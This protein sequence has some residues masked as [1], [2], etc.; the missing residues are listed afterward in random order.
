MPPASPNRNEE[1]GSGF[2]KHDI[3]RLEV[4]VYDASAVRLVQGIGDL[5]CVLEHL[6]KR[7]GSA[8]ESLFES[9]A[10][11]NSMTMKSVLS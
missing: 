10:L 11:D 7:Q 2:G 1:L 4:A 5:S 6:R 8:R 3:S 9:L